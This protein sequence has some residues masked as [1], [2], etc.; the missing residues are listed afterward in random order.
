[1]AQDAVERK[2][3]CHGTLADNRQRADLAARQLSITKKEDYWFA[4]RPPRKPR[5]MPASGHP[6]PHAARI[7]PMPCRPCIGPTDVRSTIVLTCVCMCWTMRSI[8]AWVSLPS[9]T[10]PDRMAFLA[11]RMVLISLS[12]PTPLLVSDNHQRLAGLP[13][14]LNVLG[15]SCPEA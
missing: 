14:G 15:A 13:C 1:M 6:S 8:C 5:P 10:S 11:S 3:V 2:H 4:P 7:R 12:S 9:A